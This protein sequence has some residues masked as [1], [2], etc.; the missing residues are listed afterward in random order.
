MFKTLKSY[1]FVPA[2]ILKRWEVLFLVMLA[3]AMLFCGYLEGEHQMLADKVVRL[4]VI[5][6]SDS[7]EDQALKLKVRDSVLARANELLAGVADA[8]RAAEVLQAHLPELAAAGEAVLK[9]GGYSCGI[10]AQVQTTHFP[11]KYYASF[12]L[13]AGNYT[14]LRLVIGEGEG[15][16]WWCVVFPTICTSSA[17]SWQDAAVSGGLGE[18]Q[19]ELMTVEDGEYELKFKCLEWW[20]ML[21]RQLF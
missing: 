18:D 8:T 16:N 12:A 9:Q 7:H 5:A 15:E 1:L 14:A 17:I 13:P 11:T 21:K 10:S 2:K 20:D 6:N 4:H 3:A 19:V